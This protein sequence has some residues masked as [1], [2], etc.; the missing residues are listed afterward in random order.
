MY[1]G[2]YIYSH[3]HCGWFEGGDLAVPLIAQE[4]QSQI[5]D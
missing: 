4:S 1:R 5:S 3:V 2:M